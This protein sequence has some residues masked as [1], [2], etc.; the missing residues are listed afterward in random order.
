[1]YS[2]QN[3]HT[4]TTFCDGKNSV[5]EMAQAAIESGLTSLGFSSHAFTAH[6]TSYCMMIQNYEKYRRTIINAREKYKDNL[7]IFVGLEQDYFSVKPTIRTDYLI[8][9]VHY[10]KKAGVFTPVD[11]TREDIE[12]AVEKLFGGDIFSFLREYY[13]LVSNIYDKTKCDIVGHIDLCEKFN[14][15]GVLFDRTSREYVSLYTAAV[16][17]LVSQGL[18]FEINT[19]AM[20]RGYTGQPYPYEDILR[21]IR[22][23]GGRITLS[24]DT[25]SVDTVAYK[26]DEMVYFAKQC[27]F[28]EVYVLQGHKDN[29]NFCS[30]R[31]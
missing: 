18:I 1:M 30:K 2:G 11:E 7:N 14:K 13:C 6:D 16:E 8:G 27:G 12:N 28:S 15:D 5:D 24:S 22:K 9:S 21:C 25:H 26:L 17:K 19:G 4:H 23:N 20:S 3:L 29:L 31:M 10:V